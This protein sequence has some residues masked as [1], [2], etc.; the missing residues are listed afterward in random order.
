MRLYDTARRARRAVR[1]AAE[2]ADVH[3]RHHALRRDAPRARRHVPRLRRAAA[4][5]DRPRPHG[6]AACATSPTSTTRCSPR[7]ASSAST[8]S[9]WRPG[10]GSVRRRHGGPQRAARRLARPRASSAIPDIRGFIGMV[11]DRGFAYEA[12]GS[13]YFDVSPRSRSFGSVS[14]YSPERDARSSR[15]SAAAT[16]TT[17]TSATRSTSCCGSRRRRTSRVGHDVG[18]RPPGLAHRVQRAGAARAR[19][20]DRPPRRRQR[21]DLPAPRM[22]AGAVARRRRA[23]RSCATGCTRR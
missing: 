1:A 3:V 6:H 15:A 12:G 5:A 7:P 16:S 20:D 22:R 19:H 2:R 18:A 13:V 21:P 9:T 8:T 14:N 23:S 11:L 10:G 4:P 17:R